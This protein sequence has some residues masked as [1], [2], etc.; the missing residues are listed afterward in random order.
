MRPSLTRRAPQLRVAVPAGRPLDAYY[1]DLSSIVLDH[2][3]PNEARR[4]LERMTRDRRS[5]NPVSIVQLGLGGW[6][7]RE[8]D[9]A[10][11]ELVREVADWVVSNLDERGFLPYLFPIAHTYDLEP[12][13]AS[14]MA[15]GQAT[16]LLLR[17]CEA[18]GKPSYAAA[19]AH[20]AWSLTD[21]SS[22]L[23]AVTEHGAVLQE[24]PTDP[25]AD[26]LNGWIFALF[27]LHDLAA[28]GTSLEPDVRRRADDCF[29][30]GCQTLVRRL[31]LYR[32]WPRWSRYDLFPHPLTHVASPFYHRLHI[33]LL[34]TM[35]DLAPNPVFSET[36]ALWERGARSTLATAASV[37]RK[38][39]FRAVRP[40]G[41]ARSG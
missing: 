12:P 9:P 40:R 3:G 17:A 39:A 25:P 13:W 19:A 28:A 32:T 5:A 4:A 26:V 21:S 10:W 36:T 38:V 20:A 34:A 37:G 15:Q 16:S 33:E 22:Q 24:Y 11:L 1:N 6:Q 8:A 2:G 23:V 14:A 27:G 41:R 18:V 29:R 7:V 35:S 31:P 30:L